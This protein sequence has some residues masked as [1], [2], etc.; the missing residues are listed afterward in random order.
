MRRHG[1]GLALCFGV[2]LV[3][4]GCKT[5]DQVAMRMD[6]PGLGDGSGDF[7]ANG[8]PNNL[9]RQEDGR[10]DIADFPRQ[11]HALTRRYVAAIPEQTRGFNT[12]SP[13]Y[14][15]LSGPLLADALSRRDADYAT[16]DSAIQVID[17]DA[18]SPEYGRRFPLD[19]SITQRRDSYRPRYLLQLLPTLGVNLRP[20]TTYAA[21]VTDQVPVPAQ[22]SLLQNPQLG[23]V[24]QA[25]AMDSAL[26]QHVRDV[27]APLRDFLVRE[28]IDPARVIAATVWTT[29][30]PTLPLRRGAEQ[31]ARDAETMASLP[32]EDLHWRAEY[33]DYCIIEGYVQAPGFQKGKAPYARKGGEIEWDAQGHPVQQYQRRAKFVVT[34]PKTVVMPAEGF[35]LLSFIH[36]AGGT[37]EQV[38]D[39]GRFVKFDPFTHP[40][41]LGEAGNGPSQIAAERGWASSGLAG[42]LSFDHLGG[43]VASLQGLF[44]YNLFNPVGLYGSDIQMTLERIFFRRVLERLRLDASLC[45]GAD[46]G[47]GNSEFRFDRNMQVSMGQSH[48]HWIN[49]LQVA[50]DPRPFQGVIFSGMA[51]TWI[52]ALTSGNYYRPLLATAVANLLPAERLDDAHPFLMLVEWMLGG[53]DSTAFADSILRYPTKQPPH[54]IAFSGFNDHG[55]GEPTQRP[56]LMAVGIDMVGPDLGRTYATTLFPHLE[57]AGLKQLSYPAV[58]NV[59]VP[60]YGPRT[61]VVARY[62]NTNWV[63]LQNGHDVTFEREEIKHQYGCFLQHLAEGHAP[64]VAEGFEQGGSCL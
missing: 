55:S 49:T 26:P 61:A 58:N 23:A 29:G 62:R 38:F 10:I 11:G 2:S 18:D 24:L 21:I 41:Y 22:V 56:H 40:Y 6:L 7:Y 59:D 46:P 50:S 51:G 60:G 47:P 39:R 31:V 15:P 4:A 20:N 54:V 19:V 45:P 44:G 13:V 53:V 5:S 37:A 32:V 16:A 42:H 30:D 34:I 9:R 1:L 8:F 27:Y 64:V 48:G 25:A 33:P 3:L 52:K 28:E 43:T 57:I 12:I 35:P 63:T 17:V 14:L 36:G